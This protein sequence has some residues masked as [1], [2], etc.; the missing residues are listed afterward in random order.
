M[1]NLISCPKRVS[2]GEVTEVGALS[3]VNN[4]A[5]VSWSRAGQGRAPQGTLGGPSS[6][7]TWEP[8]SVSP[9]VKTG[10]GQLPSGWCL[11][12]LRRWCCPQPPLELRTLFCC[13]ESPLHGE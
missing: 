3:Q 4:S 6:L 10:G 12:L 9:L 5:G 11:W 13:R 1:R 2:Q 7:Q 8:F